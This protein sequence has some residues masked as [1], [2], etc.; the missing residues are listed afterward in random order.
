MNSAE[1]VFY[2]LPA[3]EWSEL[4]G[5]GQH[6]GQILGNQGQ[7]Q[8][9]I[10]PSRLPSERFNLPYLKIKTSLPFEVR[11]GDNFQIRLPGFN[12]PVPAR[13]IYPQ[14]NQLTKTKK[15]EK[16][17]QCLDRYADGEK[18][19]LLALTEE[20][21]FQGL[22]E[23]ELE[24]FCRLSSS[25]LSQLALELEKEG[26]LFILEFSPLFLLSRKSFDFLLTKMMSYIEDYHQRRPAETGPSIKKIQ[27]RFKLPKP[28]LQLALNRLIKDGQVEISGEQVWRHGFEISL[29][30]EEDDIMTAIEKLLLEQKFSASSLEELARK[31]KVHPQRLETMVELLLQKK[32]VVESQDGFILH[33]SWLEEIKKEL[34]DR[35]RNGQRE[36]TVGEFKKLTGLSRKYAIPLLEFLDELGLTRR[37]GSKR[38]IL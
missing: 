33:A 24:D 3:G 13:V 14:A 31:F 11:W 6:S 8:A 22:R 17:I 23:K 21:G 7:F 37:S 19:M 34:E 15:E 9:K 30:K 38:I 5:G 32:K 26:Q 10:E 1:T 12:L 27:E 2:A 28:V 29:S 16:L 18:A 4:A 36:L 25:Q 20:A 35:K